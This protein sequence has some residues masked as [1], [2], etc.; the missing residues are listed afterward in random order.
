M[1]IKLLSLHRPGRYCIVSHLENPEK[2]FKCDSR[3]PW[4]YVEPGNVS[5]RIE[6][7]VKENYG[8]RTQNWWQSENGVQNV[9]IRLDLEAEFHF[10]HL[11]MVFRSFRPAA[12]FIERSKDFG[13]TWST[14]R[15]FAYD[16]AS[17]FPDVKEGPPR[18]HKDLVYKVVSPHIRTE[19]PYAPDIAELLKITNLRI[20]FTRLH[21][22]GDNLL[23]YRPEIDEKYWYAVYEIV[24]RGSCSCYGHAQRCVPV[25]D[26]TILTAK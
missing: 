2:C 23:D 13:K 12:M 3:Q 25:G 6:N 11:I 7:V 21:S 24:V 14:Y 16:C 9:S 19:D 26:E 5:H 18:N 20:N 17:S 4:S 1:K 15:Y 22:L 8:Y 10:T